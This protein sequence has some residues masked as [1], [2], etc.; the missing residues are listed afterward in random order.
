M[1]TQVGGYYYGSVFLLAS[2]LCWGANH[3]VVAIWLWWITC[4]AA[5]GLEGVG[6]GLRHFVGFLENYGRGKRGL[7]IFP[8]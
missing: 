5:V 1:V 6:P 4:S 2:L 8:R 7:D 3:A